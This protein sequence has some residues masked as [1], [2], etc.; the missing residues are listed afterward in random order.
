MVS[1][2]VVFTLLIFLTMQSYKFY[3]LNIE[4]ITF[5]SV[6]ILVFYVFRI[7]FK[8]GRIK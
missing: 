8:D 6:R 4:I 1:L 7:I 2:Q 3:F 5:V